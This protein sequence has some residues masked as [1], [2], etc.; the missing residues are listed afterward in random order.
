MVAGNRA[1][2]DAR[3]SWKLCEAIQSTTY[4][5]HLS[6]DRSN[7]GVKSI[8]VLKSQKDALVWVKHVERAPGDSKVHAGEVVLNV[9]LLQ[10][11]CLG[12][13]VDLPIDNC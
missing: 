9:K 1:P 12:R 3:C 2:G 8:F 13:H 6:P 5:R 4:V 7:V 11:S 10:S